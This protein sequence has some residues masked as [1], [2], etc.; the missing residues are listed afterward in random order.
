[1]IM[2]LTPP[3][4]HFKVVPQKF[5]MVWYATLAR[6]WEWGRGDHKHKIMD[7]PHEPN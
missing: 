5:E 6:E 4:P 1:M 3:S 7:M 2:T